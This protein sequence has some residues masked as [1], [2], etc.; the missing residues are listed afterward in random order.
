MYQID[1][2]KE[3]YNADNDTMPGLPDVTWADAQL[4]DIIERLEKRIAELERKLDG[5]K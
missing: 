4:L 3:R 5:A 1:N 2:L